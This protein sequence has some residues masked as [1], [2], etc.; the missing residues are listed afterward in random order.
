MS[1]QTPSLK[2]WILTD[3]ENG[4][5]ECEFCESAGG[6]SSADGSWKI[7]QR[8]L[9]G[10][11]SEGVTL[12]EIDNG[13][14]RLMVIPTR[15]MGVWRAEKPSPKGDET[16]GWKSPVRGPVHP[17]FVPLHDPNGLGWLE[18]FDELVVRCGLESNGAPEFDEQGQLL[19]PLHGRIANRPAHFVEVIVDDSARTITVRGIVE[20]T[21]FHFQK[22]RL[23][24]S[25]TTSFDS[26][27]FTVSDRVEN[28]GG[29]PARMQMLYHI[30]IGEPTL[31][32]GANIVAPIK[33]VRNRDNSQSNAAPNK[34]TGWNTYGP[35]TAGA[36]EDCFFL[37]LSS[38]EH[39]QTQLL[40]K[41]AEATGGT[42]LSY[43]KS[44]LPY[45][46]L[47]KNLA[48]SEDGYVTGL[49]PATNYPNCHSAEVAEGRAV[50][51]GAGESWSAEFTIDWLA[52]AKQVQQAEEAIRGL[53]SQEA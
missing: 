32:A 31:A 29:T 28:F 45:F 10:G 25:I 37:D 26:T 12:L 11:L 21:R 33:S 13:A 2:T 18:G 20:E 52:S 43:N 42:L 36:S 48:A 27:A 6:T 49:E 39:D 24:A 4:I 8:V 44:Q 19:Y 30:N 40:L 17:G 53:E 34:V 9:R 5:N 23:E 16:L 14:M 46:T 22:L 41:N 35:P 38:D 7:T 1:S 15:G 51:L 50:Q 3:V 47:W